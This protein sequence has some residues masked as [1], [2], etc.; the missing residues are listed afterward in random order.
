MI[1]SSFVASSF[2]T[3]CVL[4]VMRTPI[5]IDYKRR[6]LHKQKRK[7]NVCFVGLDVY[8]IDHIVPY[9]V[10]PVHRLNNLQALCPTCHS[11]KTRRESK[12][13][14]LFKKCEETQSHRYCWTCKKVVSLYFGFQNGGCF[15]CL[16]AQFGSSGRSS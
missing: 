6:V 15:S 10:H 5:P 13:I 12:H 3:K 7:C 11:R 16:G 1:Q 9:S 8:D 4:G 14:A 2:N